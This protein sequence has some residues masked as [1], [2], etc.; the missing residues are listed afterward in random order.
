MIYLISG[1]KFSGKDTAAEYISKRTTLPIYSYA[2][3]LKDILKNTLKLSTKHFSQKLK[4]KK[5]IR[6]H[7]YSAA[8]TMETFEA[9]LESYESLSVRELMQNF[10]GYVREKLD[11]NFW[12]NLLITIVTNNNIDA[13]IVSDARHLNEIELIKNKFPNVITIRLE[14]LQVKTKYESH[15]SELELDGYNFDYV[16]NNNG[17]KEDLYTKLDSILVKGGKK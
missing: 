17:T 5:L 9:D 14:R 12:V 16:I 7:D 15:I 13:F 4:E 11:E 8:S 2:Q 3:P 6:V 10:G 1:K